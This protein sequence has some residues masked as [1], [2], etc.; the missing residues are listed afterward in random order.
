M[1]LE[2]LSR[3]EI[4]E[5]LSEFGLEPSD[6]GSGYVSKEDLKEA[7]AELLESSASVESDFEFIE[8]D[9]IS[10]AHEANIQPAQGRR[11]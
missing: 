9:E 11:V 5:L 4:V 1:D 3:D 10:E 2:T 6:I 7:L 8:E